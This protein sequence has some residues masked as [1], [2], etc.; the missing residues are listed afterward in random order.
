MKPENFH[1]GSHV[2]LILLVQGT[3]SEDHWPIRLSPDAFCLL[4]H[5]NPSPVLTLQ[6]F[7]L[8]ESIKNGCWQ[9]ALGRVCPSKT[10]STGTLKGRTEERFARH[11][12][13]KLRKNFHGAEGGMN[14]QLPISLYS[15]ICSGEHSL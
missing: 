13:H 7:N 9:P 12:N 3:H 1:Y 6:H 8:R 2:M 14:Y 10:G 15:S 4:R 11:S 5:P